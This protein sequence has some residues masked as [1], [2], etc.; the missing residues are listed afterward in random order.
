[1]TWSINRSFWENLI[2]PFTMES[3]ALDLDLSKFFVRNLA[4][5]RIGLGV[6][7]RPDLKTRFRG[8]MA[9]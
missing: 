3:I 6:K 1:M 8:G 2:V 9:D 4:A 7:F 5:G